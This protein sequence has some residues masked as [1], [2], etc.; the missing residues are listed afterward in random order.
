MDKEK[1]HEAR[2][3]PEFLEYLEK[4]RVDAI[5]TKNVS[6][7]Y[8]VLDSFLVLGLE[9]E[10][11]NE[12]YQHILQI[13]FA[14]VEII[15]NENRK[16]SLEGDDLYYVR[17]FYEHGVEKWSYE[18]IEGA[19]ELL[20]VLSN[21]IDDETLC[22]AL[23]VHIIALSNERDLDTFYGTEVNLNS[24]NDDEKYGYFITNFNYDL[25]AHLDHNKDTLQ[26]EYDNL[27]HLL[28]A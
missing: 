6:A 3:N 21:I 23:K 10:K 11:I 16:L 2:T 8:E 17:A 7:L 28:D 4:T 9:E 13:S 15:V 19:K 5:A 26:K 25:K 1:L 22:D 20:F 24:S 14:N 12:I 18:N 27:K